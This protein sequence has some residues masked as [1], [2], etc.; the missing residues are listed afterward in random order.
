MK[1]IK[2]ILAEIPAVAILNQNSKV[3]KVTV[4]PEKCKAMRFACHPTGFF[5]GIEECRACKKKF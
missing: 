1:H 2:E 4:N 3:G 5:G